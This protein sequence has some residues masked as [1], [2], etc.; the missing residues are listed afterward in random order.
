MNYPKV[1]LEKRT[2]P[3]VIGPG[4]WASFH[5]RSAELEDID[6]EQYFINTVYKELKNFPCLNC[7]N[8]ALDYW[9]QHD[10]NAY[11]EM[12]NSQGKLIGMA[13]Y[14][15]EFHNAVN[16]RLSKPLM[17]HDIFE[18]I[19]INKTIGVCNEDC[20]SKDNINDNTHKGTIVRPPMM[21][22][23]ATGNKERPYLISIPE[24]NQ[25]NKYKQ[26]QLSYSDP[27]TGKHLNDLLQNSDEPRYNHIR[28]HRGFNLSHLDDTK[29]LMHNGKTHNENLMKR[30]IKIINVSAP[31]TTRQP[32][33]KSSR[34]NIRR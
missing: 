28:K 16:Y 17:P 25:S 7:R 19:Y 15:Y 27:S 30:D 33:L 3:V 18:S 12:R 26:H 32:Q 6:D 8:H 21:E 24:I 1:L 23:I 20:G 14:F 2:D 11:T 13:E 22:E 10:I 5:T 4:Y 29:I 9:N 31:G 34:R